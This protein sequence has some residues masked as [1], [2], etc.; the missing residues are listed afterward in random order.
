[1]A[2]ED[3]GENNTCYPLRKSNSPCSTPI[4]RVLPHMHRSLVCPPPTFLVVT[5]V[6][7]P[8]SALPSNKQRSHALSLCTVHCLP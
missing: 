6:R 1:M 7:R 8:H 5:M 2:P 4:V 3:R